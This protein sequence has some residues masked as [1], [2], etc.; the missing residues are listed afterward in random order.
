MFL[1]QVQGALQAIVL[2]VELVGFLFMK[3]SHVKDVQTIEGVEILFWR[4]DL[5]V[6]AG[7]QHAILVP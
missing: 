4:Q 7:L 1:S 5:S 6:Q 3:A 2:S